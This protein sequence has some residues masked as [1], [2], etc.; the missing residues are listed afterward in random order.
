M[1]GLNKDQM[2]NAVS[3]ALTPHN[4]LYSHIGIQSMW[5]GLHSSEM[6][7]TGVWAALMAGEGMTAPAQPFDGRDGLLSHQG[8]YTRDLIL[9]SHD[10]DVTGLQALHGNGG[11]Y[12]RVSSEGNTQE[13]AQILVPAV[14]E[15]CKAEE[16]DSM[17]LVV[18]SIYQWQ[19]VCDPPKWDPRNKETADHSLPYNIARN[20]LDGYIYMDSFS[21]EK[22]MDP[23]VRDLMNRITCRPN[24]DEDGS[25]Q[26][27]TVKKK[28]GETKVF[29]GG[30]PPPMQ[31]D[32]F[33]AKYNKAADYGQVDKDQAARVL[34]YW[35]NLKDCEDIGEGIS[36]IAKFGKPRPLSDKTPAA[37]D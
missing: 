9:A 13:A 7:R 35:M 4:A 16:I 33:I 12:K 14:R 3:L 8:P 17:D 18:R 11:G 37:Y 21:K 23:K 2:A 30:N 28:N 31:H 34:K 27:L 26:V 36:M 19:E 24:V 32:E 15:W 22:Y 10:D 29:R 1:M 5:K 20:I 6:I 25:P